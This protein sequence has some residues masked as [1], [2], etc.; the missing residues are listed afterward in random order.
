MKFV[1]G[2]VGQYPQQQKNQFFKRT[3]IIVSKFVNYDHFIVTNSTLIDRFVAIIVVV[4]LIY[5]FGP[6]TGEYNRVSSVTKVDRELHGNWGNGI[7]P[8]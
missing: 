4:P 2:F 3:H 8:L 7:I 5:L 6:C 1:C